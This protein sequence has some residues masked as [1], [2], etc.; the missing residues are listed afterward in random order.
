[1]S[2]VTKYR[3]GTICWVDLATSDEAGAGKFYTG[4]FGWTIDPR[5]MGEGMNYVMCKLKDQYVAAYYQQTPEQSGGLPPHWTSYIAVA[6]VN[7]SAARARELGGQVLLEPLN[8]YTSGRMAVIMDPTG[9]VVAL[10]QPQDHMGAGIV[11]EP[12]ALIWNELRTPNAKAA[13]AFYTGLFGWTIEE[14]DM[15]NMIYRL[16]L[17][18]G[19]PTAG[20]ME[21]GPEMCKD[22]PPH[23]G[24]FFAVADTDASAARAEEL[25]ATIQMPPTDI[26]EVGRFAM[27]IDPQGAHLGIIKML[28]EPTPYEG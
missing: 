27:L 28:R 3:P 16:L 2:T 26:P 19:R 21:I 13:G 12:G 1:M 15:G 11:N 5:P 18:D 10:W 9:A 6:D 24:L 4:L 17:N 7:A 8:V 22:I 14:Q 23:W 20:M 25:G